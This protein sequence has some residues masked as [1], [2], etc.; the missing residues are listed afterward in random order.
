MVQTRSQS[1]Q[2]LSVMNAVVPSEPTPVQVQP[3][4]KEDPTKHFTLCQ[5]CS[6][7][8]G[9]YDQSILLFCDHELCVPCYIE[10]DQTTSH[11]KCGHEVEYEETIEIYICQL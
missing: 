9:F 6:C 7:Q 8:I 11:C 3:L 4:P 2:Q 10:L 5:S 1:R